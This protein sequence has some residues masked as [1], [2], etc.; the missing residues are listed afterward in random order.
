MP[1]AI[2]VATAH[3][4]NLKSLYFKLNNWFSDYL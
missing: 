1:F 2:K 3:I 4:P